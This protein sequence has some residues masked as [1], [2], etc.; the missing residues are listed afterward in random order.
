[1]GSWFKRRSYDSGNGWRTTETTSPNGTTKITR[2]HTTRA[3]GNN[4]SWTT[5]STRVSGPGTG[6]TR[7][8]NHS[9][10]GTQRISSVGSARKP[11]NSAFP[12]AHGPNVVKGKKIKV[13]KGIGAPRR[14]ARRSTKADMYLGFVVIVGLGVLWVYEQIAAFF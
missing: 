9:Q 7:T 3:P 14:R 4:G 11:K 1:M 8:T 12:K 2:S 10:L 5:T 13:S 6:K